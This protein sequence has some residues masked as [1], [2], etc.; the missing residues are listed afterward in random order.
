MTPPHPLV[1]EFLAV[2]AESAG[3]TT[4]AGL[5]RACVS[6]LPVARAAIVV[7]S[8]DGW[9]LLCASDEVAAR[10]EAIQATVGDG[11]AI[12]AITG[13]APVLVPDLTAT[14][15]ARWPALLDTLDHDAPSAV[16]AFPLQ[17]GAIRLGVLDLYREAPQVLS[18]Q[19]MTS[20]TLVAH[21]VTMT[22]LNDAGRDGDPG[23]ELSPDA[24]T[25]H[26]ATGMVVA[27]LGVPARE[28]YVRLQGHAFAHGLLLGE[29]A[30]DVVARRLRLTSD[31]HD[32][33]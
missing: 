3:E 13:G 4:P 14:G 32:T 7:H 25:I 17:I 20:M 8:A 21:L 11:P 26:Q 23:W 33:R 28:A 12:D 10:I 19:D 9:E 5:C 27:Q 29:V 2:L 1:A 30:A 16:F 22:L 31:G 6:V 18:S 15:F 24:Q